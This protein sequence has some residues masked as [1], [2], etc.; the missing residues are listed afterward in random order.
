MVCEPGAEFS[1]NV[2][3]HSVAFISVDVLYVCVFSTKLVNAFRAHVVK[4]TG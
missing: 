1:Q 2:H 4:Y 3:D